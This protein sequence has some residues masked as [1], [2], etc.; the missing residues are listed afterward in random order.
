MTKETEEQQPV[1]PSFSLKSI[2]RSDMP[3]GI[4]TP[5]ASPTEL[6][7]NYHADKFETKP[8]LYGNSQEISEMILRSFKKR[9]DKLAIRL[10]GT[11]GSG[12]TL[13]MEN[14]CNELFS[15][16]YIAVLVNENIPAAYIDMI[17]HLEKVI[18]IFDEFE[19]NYRSYP[20]DG[21]RRNAAN[22]TCA[23][24]DLLTVL[25]SRDLKKSLFF[26]IDNDIGEKADA[27][28]DRPQRILYNIRFNAPG[29]KEF[30]QMCEGRGIG[31]D[32]VGYM[33]AVFDNSK[34]HG[35]DS[36]E[37]CR[38]VLS[39]S[40]GEIRYNKPAQTAADA[41][42]MLKTINIPNNY[43]RTLTVTNIINKKTKAPVVNPSNIEYHMDE[44]GIFELS[45][46]N[47]SMDKRA[48]MYSRMPDPNAPPVP[49]GP[50]NA[51]IAL[52]FDDIRKQ[53]ADGAYHAHGIKIETE[54]FTYM[55]SLSVSAPRNSGDVSPESLA[56]INDP[57]AIIY[58][59]E[60]RI[61]M[62]R[63]GRT[64]GPI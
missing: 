33:A 39:G 38:D 23:Q 5:A 48:M 22:P 53:Y 43:R 57:T 29:G 31:K 17:A 6:V 11:K 56:Y 47:F 8:L 16:G 7:L 18:V 26:F 62:K 51:T 40:D 10:Y 60:D 64:W 63:E 50:D 3:V 46:P 54:D 42:N 52:N 35:Y 58:R 1:L 37:T 59:W 41:I 32:A 55:I 9:E 28:L 30:T 13:T 24:E 27:L 14:V 2:I 36:L 21:P 20:A 61:K 12:K 19:I 44:E 45:H 34:N 49:E 25:S 15:E 4:Y